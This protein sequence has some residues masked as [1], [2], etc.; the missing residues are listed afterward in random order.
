[1]KKGKGIKDERDVTRREK[2]D[3]QKNSRGKG[4]GK[5]IGGKS[6]PSN[7]WLTVHNMINSKLLI[8]RESLARV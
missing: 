2:R 3:R 5:E 8:L 7:L 4:E 1:M 6:G